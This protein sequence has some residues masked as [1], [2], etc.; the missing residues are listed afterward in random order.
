MCSTM[1]NYQLQILNET[2]FVN[3]I[4]GIKPLLSCTREDQT[5]APWL[6]SN[7]IWSTSFWEVNG[8]KPAQSKRD[9]VDLPQ[10]N[11]LKLHCQNLIASQNLRFTREQ[12]NK[13]SLFTSCKQKALQSWTATCQTLDLKISPET[14]RRHT[15]SHESIFQ[16]PSQSPSAELTNVLDFPRTCR[17][18]CC[19]WPIDEGAKQ[20]AARAR[21]AK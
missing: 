11:S 19:L 21:S 2:H 20:P 3:K 16:R 6:K 14:K 5:L 7:V 15:S 1:L 13:I 17:G 8:C 4:N 10:E 9:F 12:S 18:S